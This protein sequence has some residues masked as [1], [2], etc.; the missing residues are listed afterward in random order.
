MWQKMLPVRL[1]EQIFENY[2]VSV[3]SPQCIFP[4]IMCGGASHGWFLSPHWTRKMP[5]SRGPRCTSG[6]Q[7]Q[8]LYFDFFFLHP[9]LQTTLKTQGPFRKCGT[10]QL[11]LTLAE[12]C[13]FTHGW[14][15]CEEATSF[16]TYPFGSFKETWGTIE[17][18]EPHFENKQLMKALL[19]SSSSRKTVFSDFSVGPGDIQ[20]LKI[21]IH[22]LLTLQMPAIARAGA[23]ASPEA[24]NSTLDSM[25][26]Q[27]VECTL[28]AH[29]LE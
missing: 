11:A 28:A 9:Q 23:R 6:K 13:M 27:E 10:Q 17:L 14:Y 1:N 16:R 25:R 2:R 29:R 22:W 20:T 21:S 15:M 26:T 7:L 12:K 3:N 18:T 24:P 8:F 19:A 4:E 5:V